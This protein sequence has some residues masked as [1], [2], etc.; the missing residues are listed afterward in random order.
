MLLLLSACVEKAPNFD[1]DAP[2]L[3]DLKAAIA[4]ARAADAERCAPELLAQAEAALIYS[5][6]EVTEQGYEE[7]STDDRISDALNAAKQAK[8]E[9]MARCHPPKP[10]VVQVQPKAKPK[11]LVAGKVLHFRG[12]HFETASARLM[13]SSYAVLDVA[14]QVLQEVPKLQVEVSAHTDSRGSAR[15]NQDLSDRRAASVV[16]YLVAH[17]VSADRLQPRGYGED[18]PIAS[19]ATAEGRALNRRVDFRVLP[20]KP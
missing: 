7:K 11:R 3:T 10:Q 1:M 16:R 13:A 8:L 2:E 19:N 6:H 5:A 14:V 12:V 20:T 4:D 18:K 17:G 9:A 15:Y